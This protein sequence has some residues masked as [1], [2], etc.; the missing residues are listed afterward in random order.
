MMV[1][2]ALHTILFWQDPESVGHTAVASSFAVAMTVWLLLDRGMLVVENPKLWWSNLVATLAITCAPICWLCGAHIVLRHI[3]ELMAVCIAIWFVLFSVFLMG[4]LSLGHK[5]VFTLGHV[6]FVL[7]LQPPEGVTSWA[8]RALLIGSIAAGSGGA[9]L[10]RRVMLH[11]L[12]AL[13]DQMC[14]VACS[15]V[16]SCS[17]SFEPSTCASA[18]PL[19][20]RSS[21]VGLTRTPP[22]SDSSSTSAPCSVPS[23]TTD[24]PQRLSRRVSKE[25]SAPAFRMLL[26][27][28]DVFV[29]VSVEAIASG[30][31]YDVVT[32]SS[33]ESALEIVRS[34]SASFDIV[35]CD[36][37]MGSVDGFGV[38]REMRR[39]LGYTGTVVMHSVDAS[40]REKCMFY[41]ADAFLTKPI[42]LPDVRG[43]WELIAR[44]QQSILWD[45]RRLAVL[46][47][48]GAVSEEN[49]EHVRQRTPQDLNAGTWLSQRLDSRVGHARI[50]LSGYEWVEVLGHGA[51][52]TVSLIRER[53]NGGL[54]V[55]K[56]IALPGVSRDQEECLANEV[57]VQA[58]LDHPHIVRLL[59]FHEEYGKLSL[60]LD[61]AGGGTLAKLLE[62]TIINGRTLDGD[63]IALWLSQLA[64]ALKYIHARG[65]LHRDLST[66][67]VFL[68]F[69]GDILVGDFG[70]STNRRHHT[71]AS[72]SHSRGGPRGGSHGGP[73]LSDRK[74]HTASP[75]ASIDA[76]TTMCG[77]PNYMSPELLNGIPYGAPSD[78]WAMGVILFELITLRAPFEG[79][80]LAGLCH[81][82]ANGLMHEDALAALQEADITDTL[83]SF[84]TSQALLHPDPQKR[85]RLEDVLAAYPLRIADH[86]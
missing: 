12:T 13:E 73:N 43:L 67:N 30:L 85:T 83:R 82:I 78:V 47:R 4:S 17:S 14:S 34:D 42:R 8:L 40:Y 29:S 25:G 18:A 72:P 46:R 48:L 11:L 62:K 56:Q 23:S 84:A 79:A 5:L 28:D 37:C 20:H 80:G 77:T 49:V 10:L 2:L 21:P 60:L 38:L 50:E 58:T 36:V 69:D 1:P 27:D 41:G 57:C 16:T 70:L 53:E 7:L 22:A 76:R 55:V 54:V 9:L 6:L 74:E 68:S 19:K 45:P 51:F 63:D 24:S 33:G 81:S 71:A 86:E 66:A 44:R 3:F 75:I 59:G 39:A 26:V 31:G 15:S 52:S 61:F 65:V 35:M 32:A 64:S